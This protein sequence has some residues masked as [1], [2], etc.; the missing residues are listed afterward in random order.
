MDFEYFLPTKFGERVTPI[1]TIYIS[2][3]RRKERIFAVKIK[4]SLLGDF[5]ILD[6]NGEVTHLAKTLQ[7]V[8]EIFLTLENQTPIIIDDDYEQVNRQEITRIINQRKQ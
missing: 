5:R 6:V 2:I 8:E 4:F 1:E 7:E 3:H